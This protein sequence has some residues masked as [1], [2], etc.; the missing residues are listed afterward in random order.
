[1]VKLEVMIG[2]MRLKNP[3]TVASGTFG[4]GSE[5][6]RFI[7]VS[8]L[9]ALVTKAVTLKPRDGN[10]PPRICETPSG[11]LN[12]IGLQNPGLDSFIKD[13]L[14]GMESM[15]LPVI[16]NVAGETADEYCR[17]CERLTRDGRV[18]AVELNLSC[19]NVDHGGL[20]FGADP[21][22]LADVVKKVRQTTDITL[23]VKLSPNVTDIRIMARA[24]ESAGADAISLINTL[25]GMSIDTKTRKPRLSRG[26]GGLSGPA[27]RPV[28]V[29]MVWEAFRT[30]KIPIIGM[31]GILT[32][33]DAL[34]FILA[35]ATAVAVGT[36]NFVNPQ[37]TVEI[38]DGLEKY[39]SDNKI[40]D[41]RAIV[42][43]VES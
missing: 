42:G 4:F 9:G 28:A 38:I 5:Y 39:C 15:G 11:M 40:E 3:V 8:R 6:E 1:M 18:Q 20:Q 34:E 23:I 30:I 19:P 36:G 25:L 21:E 37:A 13:Y 35:G 12:S 2:K 32:A 41:I 17:I 31:G 24:A 22:I 16:V 14:P 27:I 26:F 43:G 10:K 29:R 7:D 33:A